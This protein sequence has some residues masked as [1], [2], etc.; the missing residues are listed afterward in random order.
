MTTKRMTS[1]K[2]MTS[3]KDKDG[4]INEHKAEKDVYL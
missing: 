2:K 3:A 4:L 1:L